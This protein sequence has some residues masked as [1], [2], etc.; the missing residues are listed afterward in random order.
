[1]ST[2]LSPS[3][4]LIP[5]IHPSSWARPGLAGHH[6]VFISLSPYLCAG[7]HRVE[8]GTNN[9]IHISH[10]LS[11]SEVH[12]CGLSVHRAW[13]LSAQHL[14]ELARGDA[15]IGLKTRPAQA[16]S[17]LPLP[18]L[19]IAPHGAPP[20]SWL[21][22]PQTFS[23]LDSHITELLD[24]HCHYLLPREE[25]LLAFPAYHP[26]LGATQR[27]LRRQNPTLSLGAIECRD[28]FPAR[29]EQHS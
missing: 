5:V 8:T 13:D 24:T 2:V 3:S 11:F 4:S 26:E 21:S 14:I 22:H 1:M 25:L 28:G 7:I 29:V 10:P 19:Q 20:G 12:N 9:D 6:R 16:L 23:L 27:W 15:G 18:G 17:G